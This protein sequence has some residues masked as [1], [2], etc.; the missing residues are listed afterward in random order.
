MVAGHENS[1][2]ARAIQEIRAGEFDESGKRMQNT[3]ATGLARSF[4]TLAKMSASTP[5][6]TTPR[7]DAF[8]V[9]R[10]SFLLVPVIFLVGPE[11]FFEKSWS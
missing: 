10:F 4:Y 6:I 1:V 11:V 5:A 8:C 3:Q 7:L 9:G 2:E